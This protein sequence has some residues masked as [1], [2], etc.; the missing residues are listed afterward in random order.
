VGA[1]V[2]CLGQDLRAS[3]QGWDNLLI[4]PFIYGWVLAFAA[5][6]WL[7]TFLPLYLAVSAQSFIWRLS[8]APV[9]GLVIGA[10][11]SLLIFGRQDFYAPRDL[12]FPAAIGL[13][14]FL[15]GAVLK[16]RTNVIPLT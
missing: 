15:L 13:T 4:F 14:V 2:L 8:V 1:I 10:A 3:N 6:F 16:K 5:P 12:L 7:F 9:I 11:G